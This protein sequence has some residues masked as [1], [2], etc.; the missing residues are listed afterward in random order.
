MRLMDG[1]Y[2]SRSSSYRIVF[3]RNRF[4]L[5]CTV[6]WS[7]IRRHGLRHRPTFLLEQHALAPRACR[8]AERCHGPCTVAWPKPFG[9][10]P[11][12]TRS[13]GTPVPELSVRRRC[14]SSAAMADTP[15][16]EY[17]RSGARAEPGMALHRFE[18]SEPKA[19]TRH[20][21]F[22][23]RFRT[24]TSSFMVGSSASSDSILRIA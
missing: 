3:T 1:A 24:S 5:W 9:K 10:R 8:R 13:D 6:L 18:F 4:P 20:Y 21:S 17:D 22:K 23:S 11:R 15:V 7:L 14:G 16:A 12:G 2:R 19:A